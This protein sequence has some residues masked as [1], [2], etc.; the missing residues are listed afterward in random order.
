MVTT[1]LG[2]AA[3][4]LLAGRDS[5]DRP[6][7]Y[8]AGSLGH[9]AAPDTLDSPIVRGMH[10]LTF[11]YEDGTARGRASRRAR[12]A[13]SGRMLFDFKGALFW[14][15][16][17]GMGEVVFAPLYEA[18]AAEGWSS[19]SSPGSRLGSPGARSHRWS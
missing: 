15:M 3:D 11:A 2:M 13:A 7:D 16:Q 9:G 17:A 6:L 14:R 10:D 1:L 5:T 4:G 8:R 12:C 19:G 18:L